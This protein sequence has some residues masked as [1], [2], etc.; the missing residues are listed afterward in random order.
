MPITQLC[1]GN[2]NRRYKRLT[3]K[4]FCYHCHYAKFGTHPEEW[5]SAKKSK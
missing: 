1:K 3:K 4:G 5:E 2:C